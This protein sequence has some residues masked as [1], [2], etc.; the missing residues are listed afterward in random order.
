MNYM[1]TLWLGNT[2]FPETLRP[3]KKPWIQKSDIKEIQNLKY[4]HSLG[5]VAHMI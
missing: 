5:V 3:F 1:N 4:R 2:N